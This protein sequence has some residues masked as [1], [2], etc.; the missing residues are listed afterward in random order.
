MTTT[1]ATVE[2]AVEALSQAMISVE[3]AEL[4]RWIA[5][6]LIY[7]HSNARKETRREFIE[8]VIKS[9]FSEIFA[10]DRTVTVM[11]SVALVY[12]TI[13][14]TKPEGKPSGMKELLVWMLRAGQW[15]LVGRQS[16]R[17]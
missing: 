13:T 6:E 7:G 4:E 12:Q 17:V 15:K 5:E 3:R 16:V 14:R 10:S 9:R 1:K 11:D 8:G 2:Q